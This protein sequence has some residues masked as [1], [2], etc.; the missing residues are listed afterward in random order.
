MSER[1]ITSLDGFVEQ[2][3]KLNYNSELYYRG[4]NRHFELRIPSIY[5]VYPGTIAERSKEY[6]ARLFSESEEIKLDG[7]TPF[8][9]LSELQHFGG[10]TRFLDITKNSLVALYF[11]VEKA[12]EDGYVFVYRNSTLK[13]DEGDTAYLKAAVHFVDTDIVHGFIHDEDTGSENDSPTSLFIEKIVSADYKS[14]R[15]FNKYA[16][17]RADLTSA[18]IIMASKSN[19]RIAH[20]QGAF[21][22]PAFETKKNYD[23]MI[24]DINESINKLSL[25]EG[26]ED[27]IVFKIKKESKNEI[28]KGLTNLGINAGTVYPDIQHQSDNLVKYLT[29]YTNNSAGIEKNEPNIEEK[30]NTAVNGG[31]GIISAFAPL[32]TTDGEEAENYQKFMA[33]FEPNQVFII[34]K[35]DDYFAGIRGKKFVIELGTKITED[36]TGLTAQNNY[37]LI[38]GKQAGEHLVSVINLNP[39]KSISALDGLISA[40]EQSGNFATTHSIIRKLS[41]IHVSD[42]SNEQIELLAKILNQNSQVN[43]IITD[44]DVSEFYL[45]I[46]SEDNY[47][48]T[49]HD[50]EKAREFLT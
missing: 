36:E 48:G 26:V 4:E 23:E 14:G 41:N 17:I 8:K 46:L 50:V 6:Y 24:Q 21:I 40:L 19:S 30:I 34:E 25:T 31:G 7:L 2:I 18:Q 44:E 49:D 1:V 12:D 27:Q 38:S 45:D 15:I 13:T 33:E 37:A 16:Q 11:A 39:N 10:L 42:F 32:S 22:A 28:L 20:Q 5:R 3:G 9:K 43:W 47:T 29:N 35:E